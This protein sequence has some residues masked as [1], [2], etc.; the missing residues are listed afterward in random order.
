[1]H[2]SMLSHFIRVQ[3]FATLWTV[4]H[5]APL[6][7]GFSR[8]EYQSGLPCPPLEDLPNPRDRTGISS[9]SCI[10]GGFFT[11]WATWV[12]LW[13]IDSSLKNIWTQYHK[14][15]IFQFW[16]NK[17]WKTVHIKV[18][19]QASLVVQQLRICLA[20][21]GTLAWSLIREDPTC[22]RATKPMCHDYWAHVLQLL[23]PEHL[24]PM[25]CNEKP[26]Q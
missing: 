21:Q 25:L 6:S 3:L 23:K 9:I 1:M 7:M 10:A 2:V 24:E 8:Q 17:W 14:S 20:M 4:A 5:R 22:H 11:H 13:N 18:G 15:T 26:L 12:A 19:Y 16:K